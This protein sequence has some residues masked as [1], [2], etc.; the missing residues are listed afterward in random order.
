MSVLDRNGEKALTIGIN[1]EGVNGVK[2][3]KSRFVD[4]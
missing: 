1:K 3:A 4:Y 2:I